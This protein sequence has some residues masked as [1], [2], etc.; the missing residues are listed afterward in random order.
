MNGS[1]FSGNI[2][3]VVC[4]G[5]VGL[6]FTSMVELKMNSLAFTSCSRNST[7]QVGSY[8]LYLQST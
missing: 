3:T 7:P 6:S 4:N 1:S 2:T 8:A 5:P